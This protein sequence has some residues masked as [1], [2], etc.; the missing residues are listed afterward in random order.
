MVLDQQEASKS[1]RTNLIFVK[2]GGSLITDKHNRATPR[3]RVIDR[4]AQEIQRTLTVRPGLR[5]VLGHGSGS[6]GHWVAD[7][8]KTQHGVGGEAAWRGFAEVSAAAIRL[9]RIVVDTFL[10]SQVPVLS[11]QPSSS[12]RA[13]NGEISFYPLE[14]LKQALHHQLVP[15]IFGDVAFDEVKGGTILSTEVLFTFA[16]ERLQPD[17]ILLLGNAPG[18]LNADGEVISTITPSTYTEARSYLSGSGAT[19]VTGGM[20]DKVS[21]MVDLA[22]EHPD[23]RIRILSGREPDA[24]YD[25]LMNPEVASGTLIHAGNAK[26]PSERTGPN[27]PTA[28]E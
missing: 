21:R 5:I 17:W 8:Y 24:L 26:P 12:V 27:H 23:I 16:A 10:A 7:R 22:R 13:H 4:L 14:N 9:N 15:L 25:A 2:L 6:F 18:V 20:A 28:Y 3:P 11:L 1:M 19:D